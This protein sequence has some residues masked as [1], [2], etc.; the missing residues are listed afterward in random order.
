MEK[1][2]NPKSLS[3]KSKKCNICKKKNVTNIIC[4]K[5]DNIFCI[6]HLC[7]EEHNCCHNYKNDLKMSEKIVS[8]KIE[9]I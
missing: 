7:P 3:K 1:S 9:V 2:E 5:C 6:K 8:S 4:N